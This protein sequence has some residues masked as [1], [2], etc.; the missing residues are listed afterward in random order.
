MGGRIM[1]VSWGSASATV[2]SVALM[3]VALV[4]Q[5]AAAPAPAAG[6]GPA[7]AGVVS[8]ASAL[9]VTMLSVPESILAGETAAIDVSAKAGS[10]CK[11]TLTQAGRSYVSKARRLLKPKSAV[12]QFPWTQAIGEPQSDLTAQV[13]CTR[14]GRRGS[15]APVAIR[16]ANDGQVGISTPRLAKPVLVSTKNANAGLGGGKGSPAFGTVMLP[17]SQWFGGRGVDVISNGAT[18]GCP[19]GGCAAATWSYGIKFQC[20]ELVNRFLMTKGWS[21][22]IAGDAKWIYANASAVAFDK[23][24]AGDG[25]VPASGDVMVW[26]GGDYGHVAV[27]DSISGGYINFVEQNGSPS[28]RNSRRLLAGGRPDKYWT[29]NFIGYLHAKA[30]VPAAPTPSVPAPVPSKPAP[31]P[32]TPAPVPVPVT[33]VITVN[34]C[35][36]YNNCDVWNPIYV[37]SNAAVSSRIGD[38]YRGESYTARCWTTG[39]TLTDGSNATTEDDARQ[40]TSNLW[41]GIDYKGQRGYVPATWTTKSQDH[42]GLP[43]C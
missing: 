38:A 26:G 32:S 37:H 41:F 20:V 28:G 23:H 18:Y 39:R 14:K 5:V 35:N 21:G 36:T 15:T 29:L 30:N 33:S 16:V 22:R 4:G 10:K 2:G 17:G 34:P 6:S 3:S 40:F 31:V 43:G 8:A 24:A 27:V 19:P 13:S 25:Y 1:R 12:L 7:S 42:R 9:S 11:L